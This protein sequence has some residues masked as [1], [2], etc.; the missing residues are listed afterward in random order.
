MSVHESF[1]LHIRSADPPSFELAGPNLAD[2]MMRLW[3]APGQSVAPPVAGMDRKG[4]PF[5]GACHFC[6]E[7][8]HMQKS[9]PKKTNQGNRFKEKKKEGD[10]P[11]QP[12]LPSGEAVS[13]RGTASR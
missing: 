1:I 3:L 5:R 13:G 4:L 8:G 6:C 2:L 11:F 10:L 7:V 12:A 9:C